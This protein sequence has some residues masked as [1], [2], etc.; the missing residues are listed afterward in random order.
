MRT[1]IAAITVLLV[2]GGLGYLGWQMLDA[3]GDTCAVCN[4][5]LHSESAVWAE[6]DGDRRHYC[7]A[8][9]ALWAERQVGGE[10]EITEVSDYPS[11]AAL[12]PAE[13]VFVVGSNVNH[14]LMQHSIFDPQRTTLD[15][16]K[17]TGSLEF[18]RCSPSILAFS[19]RSAA[20]QFAER[21][22]GRLL[23]LDQLRQALP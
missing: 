23:T 13:A 7:C 4:R 14:C 17:K 15:Q 22:S 10:V 9:C 21:E 11:G 5:A 18:D 2:L 16:A 3:P 1:T 20:A 6:V 12:N 19:S 8:A